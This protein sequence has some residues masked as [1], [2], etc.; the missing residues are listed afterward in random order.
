M[1]GGAYRGALPSVK[2]APWILSIRHPAWYRLPMSFLKKLFGGDPEAELEK[3]EAWL[4]KGDA[5]RALETARRLVRNK[6]MAVR[7]RASTLLQEARDRVVSQALERSTGAEERGDLE[8]AVDWLEAALQHLGEG[9]Q[10]QELEG[11]RASLQQRLDSR[12]KEPARLMPDSRA[13]EPEALGGHEM[14]V[15]DQWEMLL[16]MLSDDH[17]E[18]WERRGAGTA[19]FRRAWVELN[20]GRAEEA[21]AAFDDLVARNGSDAVLHFERGRARLMLEQWQGAREDFEAAWSQLGDEPVDRA[22]D[23]MP[24]ALWGEAALGTGDAAAVLDR[25]RQL[26]KPEAGWPNLIHLYSRALLEEERFEEARDHLAAAHRHYPRRQD[27]SHGLASVL[28]RL[29]ERALAIR[30]LEVAVAPSCASGSCSKQPLHLPS[31]RLLATLHLAEGRAG[32]RVEDLLRWISRGQGG[33]LA[34]E[35]WRL[36]ARYHEVEGDPEAAEEAIT[37]AEELER[38]AKRSPGPALAAAAAAPELGGQGKTPI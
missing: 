30:V 17:E 31:L 11:R 6:D 20:E 14:S 12:P 27:F 3:A 10:R 5:V 29:G 36:V 15:D 23:L 24:P 35:D 4:A 38:Q 7:G 9:M 32:D 34:P 26:A 13:P 21:L 18:R 16:G 22:G 33:E 25:L 37:E 8:D 2:S 19:E 28:E 1:A